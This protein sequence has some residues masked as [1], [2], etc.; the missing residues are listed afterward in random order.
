MIVFAT[1]DA[2]PAYYL[3]EVI[4]DI[5]ADFTCFSSG[6]SSKVFDKYEIKNTVSPGSGQHELDAFVQQKFS[7]SNIGLAVIGTSWGDSIDKSFLQFSKKNGIRVV[8][9]VENWSWYKERFLCYGKTVLPDYILVNDDL[10]KKEAIQAGLPEEIIYALG[11]PILEKRINQEIVASDR[12]LWLSSLKIPDKNILVF[13]SENYKDDFPKESPYYQ[14]FD[15]FMA[16]E[17]IL[18]VM[19]E[20]H[21]LLIKLHPAEDVQKYDQYKSKRVSVVS[22]ADISGFIQHAD[23]IIGMG[24]MFLIELATK[25]HDIISYRSGQLKSFVGNT[26]GATCF[27]EN[28]RDLS[29]II[30]RRS[31]ISASGIEATFKG[32]T[33][34]IV[35]FINKKIS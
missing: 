19:D 25:R 17:D 22:G 11:N 15:E 18:S 7:D 12:C 23:F 8:S 29:D 13:I 27:V 14:G 10:A 2:G 5:K 9:I 35:N 28:K 3:S 34:R 6:I 30:H 20:P 1:K 16:L 24:S 33:K 31:K 32:S 4:R 21:H 26:I